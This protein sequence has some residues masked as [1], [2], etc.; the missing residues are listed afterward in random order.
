[1]PRN[2]KIRL[3]GLS[4]QTASPVDFQRSKFKT[5][6]TSD[7]FEHFKKLHPAFAFDFIS[8]NQSEFCFNGS[9]L[10]R[11][12]FIKLLDGLKRIS[13]ETFSSLNANYQFHFHEVKWSDVSVKESEFR[14]CIGD[15]NSEITPY[16][17]KVFEEARVIGFVYQ[18]I[19]YLVMYDRGHNAYKRK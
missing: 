17:F 4:R 11:P 12:D 15:K 5:G 3:E 2:S 8:M 14:K 18:G 10:G 13:A 19:F 16:Q 9:F 7:K 1:M 6:D